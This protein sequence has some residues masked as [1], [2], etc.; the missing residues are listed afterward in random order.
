MKTR[1]QSKRNSAIRRGQ[2]QAQMKKQVAE[3]DQLVL[4]MKQNEVPRKLGELG[5]A[6]QE[7]SRSMPKFIEALSS[8]IVHH[9]VHQL[10]S[11][12]YMHTWKSQLIPY[13]WISDQRPH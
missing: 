6:F 9:D 4:F 12:R 8:V 7:L 10:P 5:A 1:N 3:Y 2:K 13:I 11:G